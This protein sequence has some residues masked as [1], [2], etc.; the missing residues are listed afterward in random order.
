[1]PAVSTRHAAVASGRAA[2]GCAGFTLVEMLITLSVATTV[3]AIA[4]ALGVPA[5]RLVSED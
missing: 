1:V 4:K 3:V 2:A 5:A